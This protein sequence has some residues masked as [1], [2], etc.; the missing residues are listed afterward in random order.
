MD[1]DDTTL[2]NS[3]WSFNTYDKNVE[4]QINTELNKVCELL[5][6]NKLPLNIKKSKCILFQ[7]S[8]KKTKPFSLKTDDIS[9]EGVQHFNLL[10]LT[11][12]ENLNWNNHIKISQ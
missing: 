12:H 9:I 1:A 7:V 3:I 6:I 11:I 5:K 4:R 8:N 10:D 2:F